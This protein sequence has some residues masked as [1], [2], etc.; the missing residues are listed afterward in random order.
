MVKEKNPWLIIPSLDYERH[1]SDPNVGQLEMLENIFREIL[2]DINPKSICV[3]GCTTGNGF[4]YMIDRGIDCIVGVDINYNYLFECYSWYRQDIPHLDLVCADL[5]EA[6]FK[7]S[8]FELIY[9]ALIFEYVN[10]ETV[11]MKISRW[12]KPKGVLSVVLQMPCKDSP[13]V[14]DTEYESMKMLN[15]IMKLIDAD[16]FVSLCAKYNLKCHNVFDVELPKS[17]KFRCM[18]FAKE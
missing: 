12:L 18:Y 14:S 13:I 8:S 6:E 3:L 10:V 11:I 17:K 15:S 2:N 9:G 4:G 5:N 7:D 1:M 16:E